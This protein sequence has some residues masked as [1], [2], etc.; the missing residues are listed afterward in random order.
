MKTRILF[1]L[2]TFNFLLFT[3]APPAQAQSAW[4]GKCVTNTDVATVQGLECLFGNILQVI[5]GLA[6]IAFFVMFISGGFQYLFSS[7][8][9]KKVAAASSTLTMAILGLV[10]IIASFLILQ[11]IKK[12]T[13]ADVTNFVIPS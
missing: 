8:D 13:G 7:S 6:G 10:G 5:V 9:A 11:F 4:S 1:L 2:F 12:I 3:F